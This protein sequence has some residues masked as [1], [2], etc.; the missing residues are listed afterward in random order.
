MHELLSADPL[1]DSPIKWRFLAHSPHC[2]V[3]VVQGR[4]LNMPHVH[5][6]HDEVLYILEG[7][8]SFLLGEQ[9]LPL[10]PGEVFF[11]PAGTVHTPIIEGYQAAL[12][13]Y[14]PEFDPQNPDR[15][16]VEVPGLQ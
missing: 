6:E 1:G 4:A 8:G 14:S 13:V 15:R 9:L 12:S 16:F 7:E 2:S 3:N 10:R 5:D 11:I